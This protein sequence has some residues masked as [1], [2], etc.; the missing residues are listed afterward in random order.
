MI[1]GTLLVNGSIAPS[2]LTTVNAG[3][4]LGG[5][6]TVGSHR[7]HRRHAVAGQFD[8][9]LTVN[10]NL[11]FNAASTYRVEVSPTTADRTNVTGT[12]ALAGTVQAVPLPGSFTARPTPSS[13]PQAASAA[14]R[15]AA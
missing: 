11:T 1:G 10:G 8:R 6:G 15:S 7:D 9:H 2:V 14:L 12:A 13:T 5:N 4:T 3:G